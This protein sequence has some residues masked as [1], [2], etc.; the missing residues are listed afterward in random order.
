MC[1]YMYIIQ[2]KPLFLLDA[3]TYSNAEHGN[4]NIRIVIDMGEISCTIVYQSVHREGIIS[5]SIEVPYN[6]NEPQLNRK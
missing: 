6:V 3:F 2:I 1:I 5:K 4:S